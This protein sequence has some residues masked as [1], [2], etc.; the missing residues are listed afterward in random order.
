[1][2]VT[3]Y[4]STDTGAPVPVSNS[5]YKSAEFYMTLLKAC[6]VTGYG[7]K[8]GAGWSVAYEDT[9]TDKHRLALSN[10]NGVVEFITW[11]TAHMGICIWDSINTPGVGRIYDDSFSSVMSAGVNGWKDISIP[12][13]TVASEK[14]ICVYV[15]GLTLTNYNSKNVAW[16]V[17]ADEKSAWILFHYGAGISASAPGNSLQKLSSYHPQLFIGALKAPELPR[18]SAGNFFIGYGSSTA[19]S[20]AG[21]SSASHTLN[22]IWGLR[23][24]INTV[25]QV[26]NSPSF[27]LNKRGVIGSTSANCYSPIRLITP[28]TI[29][30][31]GLDAPKPA[32]LASNYDDYVFALLPAIGQ[33]GPENTST[34]FWQNYLADHATSYLYE[35]QTIGGVDWMPWTLES[36]G[37][38]TNMGVTD[39]PAWWP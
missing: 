13:S 5:N 37:S 29:S 39:N 9:T 35:T 4:R 7:A 20:G 38:M 11:A 3:I 8:P 33:L 34:Y 28:L 15:G 10:G 32:G 19:T 2:A 14:M 25:P 6:L 31:D 24:P 1:M 27:T 12:A 22:Y 16:T 23:T 26:S 21:S 18:N 36:T 30:Y 17:F